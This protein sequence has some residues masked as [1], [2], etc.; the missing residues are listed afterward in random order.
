[1]K[2]AEEMKA[3]FA[4]MPAKIMPNPYWVYDGDSDCIR[5]VEELCPTPF[6]LEAITDLLK[7]VRA[8]FRSVYESFHTEA[9]VL[10]VKQEDAPKLDALG[11]PRL[12]GVHSIYKQTVIVFVL[13]QHNTP[14]NS[15]ISDAFWQTHLVEQGIVPVARIHS[16]HILD[17]YQS[18]TDYSTLN[19]GTLELVMGHIT[20]DA[21]QVGFWLD[22]KGAS[23]KDHVWVGTQN[24]SG[25]FDI[26]KIPC[27]CLKK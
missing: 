6:R 27:G 5:T 4:G 13:P 20:E 7:T 15:N 25:N 2:T 1:M 24:P 26:R 21:L 14:V 11:I 23:T 22:T 3:Y 10:C 19:S 18:A 8:Y 16:H 17:P 12:L 9:Q